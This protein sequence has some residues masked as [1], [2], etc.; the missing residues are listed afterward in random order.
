MEELAETI[1]EAVHEAGHG[2]HKDPL[3]GR[4]GI[5]VALTATLMA[6][7]NIKG[8]IVVQEGN[9][10]QSHINDTWAYYQSKSTKQHLAENTR[11]ILGALKDSG[12]SAAVLEPRMKRYEDEVARYAK[13]KDQIQ[14]Q[15][16]EM[17]A[18]R[19]LLQRQHERFSVAEAVFSIAMALFGLAALTQRKALMAVGLAFTLLGFGTG[20]WA[21]ATGPKEEPV[22][23]EPVAG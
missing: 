9:L 13:E 20:L 16:Q 22:Q 17:D 12:S 1:H 4:I 7:T 10:L 2:G 5:L 3:I 11:E 8:N 15:V 6:L 14:K 21:N 19:G 18:T 23:A